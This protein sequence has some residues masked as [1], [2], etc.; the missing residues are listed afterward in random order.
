MAWLAS[1]RMWKWAASIVTVLCL[2]IGAYAASEA[3]KPAGPTIIIDKNRAGDKCVEDTA[4]MRKNHMK[5]LLHQRDETMHKGIRT[6]KYSLKNCINC[7]AS[8]KDNSVIGS[9]EHFCQ[10]CH[11]YA[12]V[13]LDCWECHASKPK[14]VQPAVATALPAPAVSVGGEKK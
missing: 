4:Y 9:D 2:S 8:I 6:T 3:A 7:H 14:S 1:K 5:L 13:S 12:A 11:T 10:S